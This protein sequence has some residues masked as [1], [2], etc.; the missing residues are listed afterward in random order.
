MNL[1]ILDLF[2]SYSTDILEHILSVCINVEELL[3]ASDDDFTDALFMR[4]MI[5]NPLKKLKELT[6]IST[7]SLTMLTVRA[8]TVHCQSLETLRFLD[9]WE[10]IRDSELKEFQTELRL[11]NKIVYFPLL[12]NLE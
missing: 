2:N 3:L 10:G 11:N 6:I 12:R 1:K 7:N 8:L 9:R 5:K 4:I